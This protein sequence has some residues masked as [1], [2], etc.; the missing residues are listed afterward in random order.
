MT[1]SQWWLAIAPV[2]DRLI[3]GRKF[4]VASRVGS[5]AGQ[6]F[7]AASDPVHAMAFGLEVILDGVAHLITDRTRG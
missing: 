3:D 1:D 2:L 5:S 7:N 4:P 6:E